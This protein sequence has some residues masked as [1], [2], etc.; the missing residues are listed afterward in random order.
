MVRKL[1]VVM[2][3]A[4]MVFVSLKTGALANAEMVGGDS[5]IYPV[6]KPI[7]WDTVVGRYR[8]LAQ[9]SQDC[10][11]IV[12][13]GMKSEGVIGYIRKHQDV[14]LPIIAFL[15]LYL[16]WLRRRARQ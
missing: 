2:V 5:L 14:F 11:M 10:F 9:V 12:E 3:I 15:V 16:F 4:I 8:K 1:I 6:S 7:P 13:K